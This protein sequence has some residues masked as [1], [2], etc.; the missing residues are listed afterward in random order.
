MQLSTRLLHARCET[1]TKL[2]NVG[3]LTAGSHALIRVRGMLPVS[4]GSDESALSPEQCRVARA[5][6]GLAAE[7][8]A[9]LAGLALSTVAGFEAG[10]THGCPET[11]VAIRH[12]LEQRGAIFGRED[13]HGEAVSFKSE[14][15]ANR[16]SRR[17]KTGIG[18][19]LVRR[20]M[21]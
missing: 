17:R 4:L 11:R 5:G 8:L 15:K 3:G 21:R 6:L 1:M 18:I 20:P 12:A 9:R 16:D 19:G 10:R 7:E 14:Q 13:G 2:E